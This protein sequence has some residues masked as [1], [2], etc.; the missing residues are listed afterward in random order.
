[1]SPRDLRAVDLTKIGDKETDMQC[2]AQGERSMVWG[3]KPRDAET[4]RFGGMGKTI[5]FKENLFP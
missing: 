4:S 5:R 2:G 3:S 1:M